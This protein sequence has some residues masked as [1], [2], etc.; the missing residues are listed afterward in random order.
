MFSGLIDSKLRSLA[1]YTWLFWKSHHIQISKLCSILVISYITLRKIAN[2]QR[3]NRRVFG[4]TSPLRLSFGPHTS[5]GRIW[6]FCPVW[7]GGKTSE[8]HCCYICIWMD[9]YSGWWFWP[10]WK[11]WKLVR[12]I[13][14]NIWKNTNVP[15]HQSVLNVK[16]QCDIF[17]ISV[18][19]GSYIC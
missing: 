8:Y 10:S 4:K 5:P 6:S 16:N 11:I 15:N 17:E 18:V 3:K 14:P 19:D 2:L 12:I 7:D 9:I 1:G 13:N